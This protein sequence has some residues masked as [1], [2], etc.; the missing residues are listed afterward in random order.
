MKAVRNMDKLFKAS[1]V[2]LPVFSLP[3]KYGIGSIGSGAKQFIDFLHDAGFTYWSILPLGPTSFGDSPYSSFSSLAVNHFL[4]DFDDLLDKDLLKKRDIGVVDWG[5]NPRSIDYGKIYANRV[6]VLKIAYN[7][8]KRGQG[9]YQRGYT[10]F[11]RKNSFTDYSCFMAL[12][13]LNDYRPWTQFKGITKEYSTDSFRDVKKDHKADIDF[14]QWTQFIFLKQWESLKEYAR[15]KDVKII[16]EMPMFVSFDSIDVY[17][18]H[19]NFLLNQ[20]GDMDFVAGYPPDV[21]YSQGQVWGNPLYNFDYLKKNNYRFLKSR[22]DFNLSLYDIVTLDHFR[23]YLE[24]YM[25]PKAAQNGLNG[26]WGR[27]P[28]ADMLNTI[29][30]DKSKIVAED[31]DFHSDALTSTLDS[32]KISDMRVLEFAFPREKGNL[33]KPANYP[34]SCYSYSSTHDCKPLKGYLDDLSSNDRK[35]AVEQI[36]LTC[37]HF[38]VKEAMDN[39]KDLTRAVLELNL[40][41][42]SEVSIQSMQDILLQGNESRINTPGTVG[43]PNWTYRITSDDLSSELASS[44]LAL[45]K[46]YGRYQS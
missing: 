44:L 6:R 17:K 11:L 23:G 21:F 7:R 36:N 13:D 4:I 26:T 10:S 27:T 42:L 25:L 39:S 22:L 33:N 2:A 37:R 35:E 46:R 12:K 18:H 24:Y 38:G 14:Y 29:I 40:A 45:N 30:T 20:S 16:G 43:M 19:R 3:G 41:S 28:G 1:G 32:L 5:S 8:F 31:V 34:Y 15:Q 9:D